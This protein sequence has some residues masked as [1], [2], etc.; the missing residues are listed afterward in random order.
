MSPFFCIRH[1]IRK[2][3]DAQ[4]AGFHSA[5]NADPFRLINTR[6]PCRL[7][8]WELCMRTV[9]W[10]TGGYEVLNRGIS[11]FKNNGALFSERLLHVENAYYWFT[12]ITDSVSKLVHYLQFGSLLC[13]ICSHDR[14]RTRDPMRGRV[15]W[16]IHGVRFIK[17]ACQCK[18][19]DNPWRVIRF[20][21]RCFLSRRK[22]SR[23]TSL[24]TVAVTNRGGVVVIRGK[25]LIWWKMKVDRKACKSDRIAMYGNNLPGSLFDDNRAT[26]RLAH[27]YYWR[28]F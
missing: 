18:I 5:N 16:W 14:L 23:A 1:F 17:P 24:I 12:T 26:S 10:I 27:L 7:E 3:Y 4:I 15:D 19:A 13:M 25:L 20:L 11:L 22:T 8:G 6:S 21:R 9:N 28:F 2:V